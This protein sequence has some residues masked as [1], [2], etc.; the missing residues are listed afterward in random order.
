MPKLPQVNARRLLNA[1]RRAG[2]EERRQ[3]GAHIIL[4][5]PETHRMTVVP[6]HP[7]AIGPDLLRAI[8]RQ[9]GLTVAQLRDLLS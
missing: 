9:A 8:L 7:G 4:R 2:F 5:H 1:L 6:D 3:T